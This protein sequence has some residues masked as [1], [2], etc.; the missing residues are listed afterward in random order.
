MA[1]TQIVMNTYL[2]KNLKPALFGIATLCLIFATVHHLAAQENSNSKVYTIVTCPAENTRK[3]ANISWAADTACGHTL[4]EYTTVKDKNWKKSMAL[5]PHRYRC[6]TYDSIYSKLPNGENFYESALFDKC[7]AEIRGL[8]P[9][10]GYKYRVIG[11]TDTSRV[12]YFKTSGAK[13]WSAC[14]ISDFHSYTP[15]PKR[16]EAAMDMVDTVAAYGSRTHA[17]VDWVLHLGDVCAWGGSYSF[18]KRLYEEEN[19]HK[20]MWGGLNGN[21]DDMTRKYFTTNK[22]IRDAN[23]YPRNGYEGEEGVCYFFEYGDVLFIMLNSEHMRKEEDLQRAQK[24][25]EDLLKSHRAKYRVVCEHYQWFFG[26][27]GRD[28]QYGR[29][30]NL[31]DKYG[32]DLALSGNNHIYVRTNALYNGEE[33]DGTKGTVY[34]QTPSSD[35]E[36]GVEC[37]NTVAPE[38]NSNIIKYRW[39]EGANTVGA[40]HLKV[41]PKKMTVVLLD[42]KGNVLDSV[43]VLAKRR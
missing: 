25:V 13:E 23:F 41:T 14:V 21:H 42:R 5:H 4:V 3:G 22:F 15:L 20:Y 36:R 32:V 9:N 17:A 2:I 12:H 10:T 29:W 30:R 31:F 8:K 6:T 33:T 1:I 27:D 37:N 18:W 24:W 39:A 26:A 38:Q 43:D 34:L 19:F 28:S 16:T 7:N 35:N 40:C 11:D